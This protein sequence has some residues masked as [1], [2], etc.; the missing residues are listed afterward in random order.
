MTSNSATALLLAYAARALLRE[1]RLHQHEKT[2]CLLHVLV[3]LNGQ[4]RPERVVCSV[5]ARVCSPARSS[6][7]R[8]LKR[9]ICLPL[10][11]SQGPSRNPRFCGLPARKV[12]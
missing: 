7:C 12:S 3:V 1:K 2:K 4:A 6:H 8:S 5:Q 11:G 9:T 10:L